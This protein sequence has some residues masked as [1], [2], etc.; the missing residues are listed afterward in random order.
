MNVIEAKAVFDGPE[1]KLNLRVAEHEGALWYDPANDAWQAVKITP[2]GW[3]IVDN[4]RFFSGAIKTQ[5]PRC[6]HSE[7]AV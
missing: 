6:C 1:I 4:P 7:A 3:E 5:R 2:D